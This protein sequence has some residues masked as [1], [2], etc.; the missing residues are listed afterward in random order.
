MKQYRE[1]PVSHFQHA[2]PVDDQ[3]HGDIDSGVRPQPKQVT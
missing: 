3:F 2:F 1:V